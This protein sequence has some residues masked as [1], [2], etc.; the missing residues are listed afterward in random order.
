MLLNVVN[1]QQLA[2]DGIFVQIIRRFSHSDVSLVGLFPPICD[3]S[4]KHFDATSKQFVPL[5]FAPNFIKN[6]LRLNN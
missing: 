3:I 6:V 5:K 4:L 2:S 1:F